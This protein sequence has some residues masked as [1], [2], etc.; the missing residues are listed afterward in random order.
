MS[1][2]HEVTR[3]A[4]LSALRDR[5]KYTVCTTG[6]PHRNWPVPIVSGNPVLSHMLFGSYVY[7]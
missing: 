4:K 1:N 5:V 2:L 6:Y 3:S 7:R